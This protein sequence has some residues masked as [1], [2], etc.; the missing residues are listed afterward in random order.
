MMK[1]LSIVLLSLLAVTMFTACGN[2]NDEPVNNKD[3]EPVNKQTVTMA[4]N[5]RWINT[6]IGYSNTIVFSQSTGKLELNYT[7]MTIKLSASYKDQNGATQLLETPEMKMKQL[8]GTVYDVEI[9]DG[10]VTYIPLVIDLGTGM[11]WYDNPISSSNSPRLVITS[12]LLYAYTTTAMRNEVNGNNGSHEQ[13]AYVF[14]LDDKGETCSLYISNFMST[15]NGAVDAPE[16]RYS[17]LTVTPT[18][19][20]YKI[21]AG[22]VES[23]YKGFY[24]L[25]DVEF[26]VYSQ[27]LSIQGSFKCNG[28]KYNVSGSL[29]PSSTY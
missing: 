12:Q 6:N 8:K 26:N 22:E 23:N 21:T 25:T 28:L 9:V 29:F 19:D 20:G 7:D 3:D 5:A 15:L 10:A 18:L 27:C 24:T 16:V 11:L 4:L 13:S 14:V 1:R 2:D 17:G